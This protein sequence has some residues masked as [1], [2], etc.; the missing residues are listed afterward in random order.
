ML[1]IYLR[2]RWDG[3]ASS[4]CTGSPNREGKRGYVVL[5]LLLLLTYHFGPILILASFSWIKGVISRRISA[6]LLSS[7]PKPQGGMLLAANLQAILRYLS[8]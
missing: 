8:R 4:R 6:L 5:Q 2:E 1:V 3:I 7:S